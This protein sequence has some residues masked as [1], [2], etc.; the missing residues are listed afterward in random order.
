MDIKKYTLPIICVLLTGANVA[1]ADDIEI[2]YSTDSSVEG[3]EPMVMFSLDWRP[4]LGSSACGGT[5]VIF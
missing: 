3:A 4:N 1:L 2:Y 5:N